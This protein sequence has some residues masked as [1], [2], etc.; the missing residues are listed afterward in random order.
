MGNWQ[1]NRLMTTKTA[2]V[3][4]IKIGITNAKHLMMAIYIDESRY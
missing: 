1:E 3:F 4:T 2:N